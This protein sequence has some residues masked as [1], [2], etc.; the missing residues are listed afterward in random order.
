MDSEISSF[1]QQLPPA[2]DAALWVI[3]QLRVAGHEALLAG[4]CVRDLLLGERPKDYDVATDARPERVIDLFR[5]T[6]KVGVQFGVVLVRSR[7]DWLEVA[8]FRSDGEYVDGRRPSTVSFGDA[9]ADAL[10]RD[11]TVNGMFLDPVAGEVR[12]YVGGRV[13]LEAGLIR[14][15][16]NPAE[17]FAED[18][19]RLLRAVRF[20][21]RLDFKLEAETKLAMQRQASSLPQVAAERRREELSK[22][23]GHPR[24]ALAM[25]MLRV[26]G[27]LDS[28]W[29]DASWLPEQRDRAA[30]LLPH[31]PVDAPWELSLAIL[32]S[33]RSPREVEVISRALACSNEERQSLI[34]LVDKQDALQSPGELTLAELKRLLAARDFENLRV[35]QRALNALSPEGSRLDQILD[36]RIKAIP[37]ESIAPQPF[38]T[39]T[40]LQNWGIEPGP[41]FKR[42]LDAVYTAQLNE[43]FSDRDAAVTLAKQVL[44][45][46]N[47][48]S[49]GV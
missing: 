2:A 40:D 35:W 43:E 48:A 10:R 16:G 24:R 30:R 31:L 25:E 9:R 4:G 19:L 3:K 44:D 38:V 12:D 34:W 5:H 22:M 32:L 20:A 1:G 45:Q 17:R 8:T 41:V 28:L 7:K 36:Q 42:V 14:A 49:G 23:L 37:P 39:G 6:R 18:Y 33:D 11:F 26:C 15:I 46:E 29:Q 21:A 47:I 13:D 27:L